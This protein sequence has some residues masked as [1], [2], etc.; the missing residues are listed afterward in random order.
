[1]KKMALVLQGG[2]ALGA[3]EYG[4]VTKLVELGWEPTAVSGVSIGAVNAAAIAGARDGDIVASLHAVWQAITLPQ[5][6]WL[7]AA[8]QGSLSLLGNPNFW[9]S[10]SDYLD[11]ARW[12]SLCDT[13]PM[14]ATLNRHCDFAQ[15]NDQRHMRIAV[16]ATNLHTGGPS[17][18]CNYHAAGAHT[19]A[20]NHAS[21]AGALSAAHVLASG[22]LPPGFPSTAIDERHYWDGGLFSNTPID[23]L[24]NMLEPAEIETLPIFVVDLFPTDGQPAPAN[25]IEVQ[26]RAIALQYQN[27]FWAQYGGNGQ[28]EGFVAMLAALEKEVAPDSALRKAPA[29]Q[30]LARLRALENIEVIASAA[31]PAGGDHDFSAYGVRKAYEAGRAAVVA[32]FDKAARPALRSAA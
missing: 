2:G 10:R 11:M 14:L 30:W 29:F 4:V 28:R 21:T 23:A 5:V 18:F 6:P 13:S 1:M 24:L 20:A 12:T 19:A 32:H 27:R 15:L 31:A 8:M 17:T 7:P 16:T 25:L 22:S 9:R 3:F 26:T